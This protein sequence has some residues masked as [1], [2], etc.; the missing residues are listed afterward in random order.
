[1]SHF[2]THFMVSES[3][4][5][6]FWLKVFHGIAWKALTGAGV[7]TEGSAE[8]GSLTRLTS[9]VACF[10]ELLLQC[11]MPLC[12]LSPVQV[13]W[14]R[15]RCWGKRDRERWGD[16]KSKGESKMSDVFQN[17]WWRHT[18]VSVV[19][20]DRTKQTCAVWEGTPQ[21]PLLSPW[22]LPRVC[23]LGGWVDLITGRSSTLV[24]GQMPRNKEQKNFLCWRD[25]WGKKQRLCDSMPTLCLSECNALS[26]TSHNAWK[27]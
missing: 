19:F 3:R 13:W 25:W 27:L 22:K 7:L 24:K 26:A 16:R 20:A 12:M 18:I 9:A 17:L 2:I 14:E 15:W 6:R 11:H 4:L 10:L 21:E 23:V 1:M 8:E 5:Q